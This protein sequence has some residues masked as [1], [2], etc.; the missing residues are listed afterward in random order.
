MSQR[1]QKIAYFWYSVLYTPSPLLPPAP[2]RFYDNGPCISIW[3]K[4]FKKPRERKRKTK[5]EET[6]GPLVF[7]GSRGIKL[8]GCRCCLGRGGGAGACTGAHWATVATRGEQAEEDE[9]P[10]RALAHRFKLPAAAAAAAAAADSSP[11]RVPRAEACRDAPPEAA[12]PGVPWGLPRGEER[13]DAPPE[14]APPGVRRRA[15]RGLH[16]GAS[17]LMQHRRDYRE[18]CRVAQQAGVPRLKQHHRKHS[19]GRRVRKHAGAPSLK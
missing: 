10:P 14:A 5:R 3:P 7:A 17:R 1:K 8:G 19:G 12:P 2:V 16:A 6:T 13:L 4:K 18:G 9:A 15:L 11:W